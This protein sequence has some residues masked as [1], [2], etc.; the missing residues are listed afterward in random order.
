MR[1]LLAAAALLAMTGAMAGAAS[2]AEAV[3]RGQATPA[4][5]FELAAGATLEVR[6][7][8][9]SQADAPEALGS[10]SVPVRRRGPIPFV[11]RY[12][13]AAI[14][15]EGRY[16]VSADLVQGGQAIQRG[17]APV[18]TGGAG[19]TAGIA[20]AALAEPEPAAAADAAT[21]ALVGS[22]TLGGL[23]GEAAVA[24]GV[25]SSLTLTAAGSAE[26]NGGCNNFHGTY[27]L[28]GET[29]RF[30]PIASTRR[31]CPPPVMEQETRFFAALDATRGMRIEAGSLL[32]LDASG[33]TA[34]RL[35]R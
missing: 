6:L 23:T 33:A 10:V 31:A 34:A 28:E 3:I 8:D 21:T 35:S 29:L 22:W 2:A 15:A 30:G 17:E 12:D 27:S 25:V 32:L 7:L 14:E 20:L 4:E 18:L 26:G 9:V 24:P 11:L 1:A 13:A 5:G 19:R 16:A